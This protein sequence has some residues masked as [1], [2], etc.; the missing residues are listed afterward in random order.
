MGG[1]WVAAGDTGRSHRAPAAA[2]PPGKTP[3]ANYDAMKRL[4]RIPLRVVC[5]TSALFSATGAAL[6]EPPAAALPASIPAGNHYYIS[7]SGADDHDGRTPRTAWRTI[8]R[9]N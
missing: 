8:A 4:T 6:S 9:V 5:L 2:F 1:G 7:P 3:G